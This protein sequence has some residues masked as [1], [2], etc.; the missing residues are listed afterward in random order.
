VRADEAAVEGLTRGEAI[1]A[2]EQAMAVSTNRWEHLEE[3][4]GTEWA[5]RLAGSS[6]LKMQALVQAPP[7]VGAE[8]SDARIRRALELE[9]EIEIRLAA[10]LAQMADDGAWARLRFVSSV[11]YAEQRLGLRR[12]AARIRVRVARALRRLP[13]VLD[14]Y[15]RGEIGLEAAWL[16]VRAIGV[17]EAGESAQRAWIDRARESTVKRLRDEI[18]MADPSGR[19]ASDARWHA[20]LRREAGTATRKAAILGR[21]AADAR[22]SDVFLRL[23]LPSDLAEAFVGA[24][25]AARDGLMR[26]VAAVPWD[27]GWP[28]PDP[29]GSVRAAREFFVRCRRAP[30]WVGLLAL[31][32]DFIATWDVED[33]ACRPAG[34]RIF[35]RD[36][37]RCA[38]PGC[39]S[40]RNLEV[41]HITYRSRG[42]GNE[43][44]NRLTL[45]RFH[46]Q[47][48]EHGGLARCRGRAPLG[49]IWTLGRRACGGT[50]RNEIRQRERSCRSRSSP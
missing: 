34:R 42:G 13:R 28:E 20:G 16:V 14:A 44:D 18:R 19:P 37:W 6:L 47:R 7:C 39:T 33:P 3:A 38:A 43:P 31:I 48:G 17:G 30:A 29:P 10:L 4:G 9:N 5:L 26:K 40:R 41:H 45:C 35:V 2:R 12:S 27:Q 24:M 23:R 15:H 36:G 32:E 8:E 22:G 21:R 46:H 49:I 50:Y 11:H 1:A 25:G